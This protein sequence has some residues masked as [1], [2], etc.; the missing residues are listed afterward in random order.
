MVDPL[1]SRGAVEETATSAVTALHGKDWK[2]KDVSLDNV[3][4]DITF[5]DKKTRVVARVEVKGIG[6][7]VPIILLTANELRAVRAVRDVRDEAD[8]HLAVVTRVL[9]KPSVMESSA[10]Q[11]ITAAEPYVYKASLPSS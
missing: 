4:W 11:A 1:L 7:D 5:T 8:W 6:G 9:T 2:A 3:G 10:A